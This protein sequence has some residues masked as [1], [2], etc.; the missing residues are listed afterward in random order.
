MSMSLQAEILDVV[1]QMDD[2][3]VDVSERSNSYMVN[4]FLNMEAY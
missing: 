2:L 4:A 1:S 3:S